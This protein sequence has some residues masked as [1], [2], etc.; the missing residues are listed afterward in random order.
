[1]RRTT[2][3]ALLER[4]EAL[5]LDAYGVLLDEGGA[6]PGAVALVARLREVGRPFWVL[7]NDAS[8]LPETTSVR[9][10]SQGLPIEAER[11]ITAGSL[12]PGAFEERALEG[13]PCAVLGTADSR[14]YVERAGGEVV[15][16]TEPFEVVVLCDEA[17]YP[18]LETLDAV[19][20]G[21]ARRVEAGE[22]VTL[23]L[24]NPDLYYPKGGG[25]FGVGAGSLAALLEAILAQRY[26]GREE[27]RFTRL[28]K[29]FAPIFERA[30]ALAGTRDLVLLGD[31]LA[32][33]IRGANDFGIDSVLVG[34]GL[35]PVDRDWQDGEPRPDWLLDEL[36]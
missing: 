16:A 33:D 27:L 30:V 4:Y 17:G 25:A 14:A 11:I 36:G 24:P 6:H 13:T 31:Q 21:I 35:T 12:L 20:S 19:L 8:R 18:L 29:P 1:M 34:T 22:P 3:D 32:T 2:V 7:T 9:L 15:A 10:H 28:G 26:P 5:L 23:L